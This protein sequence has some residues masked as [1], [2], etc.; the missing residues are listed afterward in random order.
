[1]ASGCQP[2]DP[3]PP[4]PPPT[5]TPLTRWIFDFGQNIA[6]F[7]T[8]KLPSSHDI[9]DGS[10]IRLEHAEI[11]HA[12]PSAAD[13]FNTYCHTQEAVGHPLRHEPCAPH[14]GKGHKTP[15]RY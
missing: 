9:P 5:P 13:T 2:V 4:A 3:F 7:V 15:D 14:P 11:L 12:G 6:G 1:M 10:S 8:L